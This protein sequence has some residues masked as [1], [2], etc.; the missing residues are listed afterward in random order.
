MLEI[1]KRILL[2]SIREIAG[3]IICHGHDWEV[4]GTLQ[5]SDGKVLLEFMKCRKCGMRKAK[6]RSFKLLIPYLKLA[7]IFNFWEAGVMTDEE[8]SKFLSDPQ[9]DTE[10]I[11]KR[12][13]E[14]ICFFS[15]SL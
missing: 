3:L 14:R 6:N 1:I 8:I 7:N 13:F 9:C 15:P 4:T 11:L 12:V 2:I 5:A 10:G